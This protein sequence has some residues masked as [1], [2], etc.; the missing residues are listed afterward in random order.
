MR[1]IKF[2]CNL[3]TDMVKYIPSICRS[4]GM[5]DAPDSKSGDGNIVR[6]QV[7]PPAPNRKPSLVKGSVFI[8]QKGITMDIITIGEILIDLTQT[9]REENIG[10]FAAYPGG[11]PANVAVA[12]AR[13][14]AKAGF[15]G[16][17]GRDGF[18][19]TLRKTLVDNGVDA[20]HLAVDAD[21]P[22]TLAVVSVNEAGDRSFSFYRGADGQLSAEEIPDDVLQAARIV[23]FGSVSLTEEI[24]RHAVLDAA[25]RAKALGR[26]IAYD[27]NYRESLWESEEAAAEQMRKLLPLTDIL[28]VSEE[29]FRLLAGTEDLEIGSRRLSLLGISLV[30]VT[31]GE[32][33]AFY[34]FGDKTGSVA[35]VPCV[36]GDTNGAGDSFFG[37][38]LSRL[39]HEDLAEISISSLEAILRFANRAASLT[40]SRRGAI[41]AMPFLKEVSGQ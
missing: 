35:G 1:E 26:V 31:L 3:P 17:V 8:L 11:A 29:E 21:H 10:H 13:L 14:G 38:V 41:P 7:P 22:T 9:G 36:V 40:T 37:A 5:A 12:A 25:K 20:S 28:K 27:P 4:G 33:G 6:V 18:G 34:R 2:P 15:I 39:C 24:S 19:E 23:Y 16:K 30:L 32:K